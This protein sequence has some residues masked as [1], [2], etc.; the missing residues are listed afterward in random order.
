MFTISKNLKDDTIM[1]GI[2]DIIKE[3][4]LTKNEQ[5]KLYLKL[6]ENRIYDLKFLQ[7]KIYITLEN[8]DMLIFK[9]ANFSIYSL[10]NRLKLLSDSRFLEPTSHYHLEKYISWSNDEVEFLKKNV[11]TLSLDELCT[12]LKKSNY[13]VESKKIQLK[14]YPIKPWDCKELEFLKSNLH[15]SSYYLAEKLN[16]SIAAIRSKKKVL[17]DSLET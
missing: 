11:N 10:F 8:G 6:R 13:Q 1:D 4:P 5:S 12:Q 7:K 14:L 3:F 2:K 17:L 16:R 9:N 15:K